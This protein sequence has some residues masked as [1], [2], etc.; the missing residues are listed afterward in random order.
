[1]ILIQ[2]VKPATYKLDDELMVVVFQQYLMNVRLH[3]PRT[4]RI[5]GRDRVYLFH[6]EAA[7]DECEPSYCILSKNIHKCNDLQVLIALVDFLNKPQS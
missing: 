2:A 1:M 6:T 4:Y 7:R 5:K 3:E